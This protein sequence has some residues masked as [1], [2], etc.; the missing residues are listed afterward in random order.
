MLIALRRACMHVFSK[1][2][3]SQLWG[4]QAQRTLKARSIS[5]YV[6]T[7]D[8]LKLFGVRCRFRRWSSWEFQP[9][10]ARRT[11]ATLAA[12]H[13]G[14]RRNEGHVSRS[15]SSADRAAAQP[16][17]PA[18][19]TVTSGSHRPRGL[20]ACDSGAG[21]RQTDDRC[22]ALQRRGDLFRVPDVRPLLDLVGEPRFCARQ[23]VRR[24]LLVDYRR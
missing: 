3:S 20:S 18:L 23:R 21:Q 15:P 17:A 16:I 7:R 11:A 5:R 4:R 9:L 13:S 22:V 14:P 19:I 2:G 10:D 8:Q 12:A 1:T 6:T 24:R